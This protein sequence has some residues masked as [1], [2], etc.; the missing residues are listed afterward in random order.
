MKSIAVFVVL[1]GLLGSTLATDDYIV[2]VNY[3]YF[4]LFP[5]TQSQTLNATHY[6]DKTSIP[7]LSVNFS[8]GSSKV[9]SCSD[10]NT[11]V[12]ATESIAL[13]GKLINGNCANLAVQAPNYTL[14]NASDASSGLLITF[15][16]VVDADNKAVGPQLVVELTCDPAATI[17]EQIIFNV[18]DVTGN[19][20]RING[21][22]SSGC[23]L[24]SLNALIDF[25]AQNMTAFAIL[26]GV[27]GLILTFF[28]LKMVNLAV[29]VIAAT[30]GTLI[31]GTLLFEF[32]SAQNAPWILW[33]IFGVSLLLGLALGFVALKF[34]KAA[35]FLVGG[36]LGVVGG[37]MLYNAVLSHFLAGQGIDGTVPFY[38]TLVICA[39]IGGGVALL[40]LAD[41]LII[42]TSVIGAYMVVRAIS[43]FAGHF[44]SESAVA[45]GLA[46]YD[47]ITYVYLVG[48]VVL[49]GLGMFFQFS[50]K[51]KKDEEEEQLHM[52][53]DAY[54]RY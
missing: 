51:P 26:F 28:G 36:V 38:I 6:I 33:T 16:P 32:T 10:P 3:T 45:N 37:L 19:V 42:A 52:P 4:S 40:I 18:T 43:C 13:L 11:T 22:S 20:I 46:T 24:A 29:F 48:I 50:T 2:N 53:R 15:P 49:A 5:F 23:H 14:I 7:T 17:V 30:A 21:A 9:Q 8:L 31:T 35:Y 25:F 54:Y 1:L 34:E 39:V 44:P 47:V 41:I 12:Y 27:I